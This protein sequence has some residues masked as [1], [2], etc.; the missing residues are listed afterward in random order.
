MLSAV[1]AVLFGLSLLPGR[2]PL[3]RRFAERISGGIVPDGADA[4]C[5]RLTWI[6]FFL[7]L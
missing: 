2:T 6:W 5:R 4:Y 1:F 7:L 3:C